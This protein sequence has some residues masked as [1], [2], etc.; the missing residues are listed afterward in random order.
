MNATPAAGAGARAGPTLD[1]VYI[2]EAPEGIALALRPAGMTARSYAY[3][4]DGAIRSALF[5]AV[6]I[7]LASFQQLGTALVLLTLFMLEWLYPVLF[8]LLPGSATPGKRALGLR[9]VMNS[10][11]PVTP[12]ASMLRN[13]LRA[14]DFVPFG[15]ALGLLL[16]LLRPDFKRL[17]DLAA[18]TLVVH[19]QIA[20]LDGAWPDAEPLPPALALTPRAQAA[21]IAWAGRSARLTPERAAELARLARPATRAVTSP[22]ASAQGDARALLGVAHWLLGRR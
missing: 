8:E 19:T 7:A 13:L 2:A 22:Q 20:R 6:L 16:M 4:I 21:V 10:G 15:Y 3:L 5:L 18:G 12:A 17:G 9:V 14:A 1:T 11:L